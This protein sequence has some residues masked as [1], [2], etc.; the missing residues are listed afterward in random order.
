MSQ[1]DQCYR[2][3]KPLSLGSPSPPSSPSSGPPNHPLR[4]P[5][6]HLRLCTVMRAQHFPNSPAIGVP[7]CSS[8]QREPR[9]GMISKPVVLSWVVIRH[10]LHPFMC[11]LIH[12]RT[13]RVR[14][15]RCTW[16]RMSESS[17]GS[18]YR[19]RG[20]CPDESQCGRQI[21]AL[22][23]LQNNTHNVWGVHQYWCTRGHC[24]L[25]WDPHTG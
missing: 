25:Q 10:F 20:F 23:L 8:L 16:E 4:A 22:S 13:F 24:S 5:H 18:Q 7:I 3:C 12:P 17:T 6:H 9:I 1:G 2:T 21:D 19:L 11:P 14:S 15:P